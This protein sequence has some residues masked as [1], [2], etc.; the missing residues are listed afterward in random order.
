M[1]P[2]VLESF[3]L[4]ETLSPC[5]C[6][7]L[8]SNF[9]FDPSKRYM[10]EV[11]SKEDRS[12]AFA[13]DAINIIK[14]METELFIR[15]RPGKSLVF[16]MDIDVTKIAAC[17]QI[18]TKC[19]VIC[20]GT[21]P[22]HWMSTQCLIK[23]QMCDMCYQNPDAKTRVELATE[24]KVFLIVAQDEPINSYPFS[25]VA[26]WPQSNNDASDFTRD[27]CNAAKKINDKYAHTKFSGN[28]T[29]GASLETKYIAATQLDFMDEKHNCTAGTDNKHNVKN[30][31]HHI[32]G[33][34]SAASFV[35]CMIYCNVFRQSNTSKELT[36]PKDFISDK[37]VEDLLVIKP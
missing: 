15:V 36:C 4:M 23:E 33:V 22:N 30:D 10:R 29:D 8:K 16:T 17:L 3:C 2:V 24:V 34:N 1:V 31:R 26:C 11:N 18:N 19:K 13:C 37:K 6:E 20:V 35:N 32:G 5:A 7:C 9:K 21:K 25:V 12:S 28:S 27:C 14:S